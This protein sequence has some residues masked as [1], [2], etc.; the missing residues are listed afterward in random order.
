[1]NPPVIAAMILCMSATV[2]RAADH[3][4]FFAKHCLECHDADTK[5]GGLDLVAL[6]WDVS[7]PTTLDRWI[8]VFDKVEKQQMPP[9]DKKERPDDDERAGFLTALRTDLHAA[10]IA[11]QKRDGRVVLR[12]LNRVE[13]ENT[14]HDLLAIDLPLQH[15]LPEDTPSHGFDNVSEGLRLSMLHMGQFLEA[16]DAAISAALDLRQRPEGLNQRFRYHD[17]E[18]VIDDQKKNGKEQ[19]RS[20]RVL[21]DAVVIFDDNSPTTLRQFKF[22]E[23]GRYRIR[24]S[25]YAVQARERPIWLKIYDTDF[26]TRNLLGYFDISVEGKREVE[27]IATL[28]KGKLLELEP[29]DTNYDEKG[30]ALWGNDAGSY[31]GRGVAIE[32]IDVEG[33]LLDSWPP[34]SV[35]RLF[36][37]LEVKAIESD[38]PIR[39]GPAFSIAADDLRIAAEKVLLDF[40]SRAF[41]RPVTATEVERYVNLAQQ[42]F[43]ENHSFEDAMRVAFRAV[44]TSPRFL[45]LE[46]Q[47][48]KVDDW[49]LASRL[50][51]FLW[52]TCPDEKLLALAAQDVLHK[53]DVLRGQVERFWSLQRPAR[54]RRTSSVNGLS[55]DRLILPSR[56]RSSTRSSTTFLKGRREEKMTKKRLTG[57]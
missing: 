56:T 39:R 35:A 33:P 53:S 48:G 3:E 22:R 2:I 26:K 30:K 11:K 45:F 40:A 21:P 37:D 13:Y 51:Y 50:S 1:M 7:D 49:A 42:G 24:V 20:F 29:F 41:R 17:E 31:H 46:E 10:S 27:V 4:A 52:S 9:P 16:A 32:W 54:L 44:L 6:P 12:R 18:S 28:E 14:L 23:R 36:G 8:E 25:C 47:P 38:K 34:P 19:W 57:S 43:D 55:Y 15:Y 5:K